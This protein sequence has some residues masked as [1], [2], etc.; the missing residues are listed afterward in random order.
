M[1]I[2]S[3]KIRPVI[4]YPA[5]LDIRYP[6]YRL[7][8]YPENQYAVHPY[9]L[10]LNNYGTCKYR[11]RYLFLFNL[12]IYGMVYDVASCQIWRR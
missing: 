12:T 3:T 6:A 9:F 7:A 5:S 11:Y 4:R 10:V 1:P 2:I 8:G